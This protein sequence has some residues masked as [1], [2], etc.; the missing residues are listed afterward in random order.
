METL[1]DR[2][3]IYVHYAASLGWTIKTF[4]EWLHS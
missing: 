4:D 2:Y 3:N 1:Q